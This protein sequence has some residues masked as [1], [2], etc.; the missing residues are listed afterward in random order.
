[1]LA[2]YAAAGSAHLHDPCVIA[3]LVSPELFSSVEAFCEVEVQSEPTIGRSVVA[4]S[5]RDDVGHHPNCLVMTDCDSDR[6]FGLL[7]ARLATLN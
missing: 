7:E 4:V 6:L 5:K 1:M 2:Y 3:Y